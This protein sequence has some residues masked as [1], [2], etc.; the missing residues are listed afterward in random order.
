MSDDDR[1]VTKQ[2]SGAALWSYAGAFADRAMRFGVFVVV[3]RLVSPSEFGLAVLSLLIVDALQ[4]VLDTGISTALIQ[5]K[6]LSQPQLDT[7]FLITMAAAALMSAALFFGA[8]TLSSLVHNGRI[9][10]LLRVLAVGPL[11]N[12]AGAVQV[13]L[14]ERE[15]GFKK[16]AFRTASSSLFGGTAAILLALGGFG[17]WALILRNLFGSMCGTVIAWMATSY[18]PGLHF[19]LHAVRTVAPAGLR[20]WGAGVANQ[21]NGKGFDFLA[22]IFLGV[23]ALGALRIAGQTVMLLIELT[24]GPMM[25][26]GYAVLSRNRH[27]PKLFEETLVAV[28]SLAALLIFPAFA[29]LY[30]TADVLLPLMFGSRWAP[31]AAITPYMCAV[32]PALYWYVLVSVALF[33]SGRADRM[34][35]WALIEA[36][37]TAVVGYLGAHFGL[38]GLATAGVLR[39]YLMTP[40][41]WHWLHRDV[42]VNPRLLLSPALPSVAASMVMAVVVA[43]A[44]LQLTPL[45]KPGML[46]CSLV[47]IGIVTFVLLLPLTARNLILQL[48]TE[49]RRPNAAFNG[50]LAERLIGCLVRVGYLRNEA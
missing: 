35:H 3:A 47:A 44:K 45:L 2:V 39:L 33:A 50:R 22:G 19:D 13:A 30:T 26:V 12:G 5:Q 23:A 8:S 36:G 40:L 37:I 6:E 46:V 11:I 41:G 17:V 48:M 28:A 21:I 38:V 24:I 18:R 43:M 4:A 49:I 34:L 29:G 32:A 27:N 31:A 15:I 20:L 10:P 1:G 9:I 25:G 14:V 7:A 16:L 42:G